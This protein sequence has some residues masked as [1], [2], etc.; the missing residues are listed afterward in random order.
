MLWLALAI[1]FNPTV[2]EANLIMKNTSQS[3]QWNDKLHGP[4]MSFIWKK[5]IDTLRKR[6]AIQVLFLLY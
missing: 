5:T 1:H 6:Y 3:I 2:K 4:S